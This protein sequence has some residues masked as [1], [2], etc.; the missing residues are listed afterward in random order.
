MHAPRSP[1]RNWQTSAATRRR[2]AAP[3]RRATTCSRCVC[4]VLTTV[5]SDHHGAGMSRAPLTTERLAVLG[6]CL[7]PVDHLPHGLPVQA[8][9][10]LV[11][12]Q[13]LPPEHQRERQHLPGYPPGPVEPGTDHLE[14]YVGAAHSPSLA[15]DLLDADRYA[16]SAAPPTDRQTRTPTTRSCRTLRTSTRRTA[17]ATKTRLASGRGSTRCNLRIRAP[18][19]TARRRW[20]LRRADAPWQPT[21]RP[22][23]ARGAVAHGAAP[24]IGW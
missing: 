10:G 6:R 23:V 18:R 2:R 15:L 14:G 8:A 21:H 7:F 12:D 3:A 24:Y 17:P 19:A 1:R 16:P 4:P 22:P 11:P 13:D 5:A 9:Q 20:P